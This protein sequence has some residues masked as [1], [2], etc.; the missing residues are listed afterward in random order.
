MAKIVLSPDERFEHFHNAESETELLE[1]EVEFS[2]QEKTVKLIK[3]EKI[4]IGPNEF[5]CMRNI[6]QTEAVLSCKHVR[7]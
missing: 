2:F 3:G 1:G 6:G 4:S 5:H 7:V